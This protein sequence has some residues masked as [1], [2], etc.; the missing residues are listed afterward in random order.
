MHVYIDRH[1]H[2][3][4]Q[5]AAPAALGDAEVPAGV[6]AGD[7]VGDAEPGQQHPADR[8]ALQRLCVLQVVVVDLVV[9]HRATLVLGHTGS[10]PLSRG[11]PA[12]APRCPPHARSWRDAP[13]S[14]AGPGR[15]GRSGRCCSSELVMFCSII[16][17][18]S[19]SSLMRIRAS[20]AAAVTDEEPLSSAMARC[21]RESARR[22]SAAG[23]PPVVCASACSRWVTS[24]GSSRRVAARS[25]APTSTTCRRIRA[26]SSSSPSARASR[27]G[28]AAARS[29]EGSHERAAVPPAPRLHQTGLLQRLDRLADGD[30]ADPQPLGQLALRRQL[31][32]DGHHAELDQR[33]DPLDGLLEGVAVPHR[34]QQGVVGSSGHG[35]G[36]TLTGRLG[37]CFSPG[38]G[39]TTVHCHSDRTGRPRWLTAPRCS[40][41]TPCAPKSSA[42]RSTRSSSRSPTCRAG[43]RAS[44]CT[45]RTSWSTCWSTAPRAATTCWLSTS[46]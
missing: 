19:S 2:G 28:S 5:Q 20:A 30:P 42:A 39:L 18:A 44:G 33:Q 13:C 37:R 24:A 14:A 10:C 23:S 31:L 35:G 11:R 26:S 38:N 46:T 1:Q 40:R 36:R 6:V 29:G 16:G 25:A 4:D 7:H 9:L 22:R 17:M 41:S 34:T 32:V 21:S 12:A 27:R 3:G 15:P 8:A 43:S 45:R